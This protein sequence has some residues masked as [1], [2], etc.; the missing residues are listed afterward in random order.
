[1]M[2]LLS[3]AASVIG[4]AWLSLMI[5]APAFFVCYAAWTRWSQYRA[6]KRAMR[7]V[8]EHRRP[9]PGG[10]GT[11]KWTTGGPGRADYFAIDLPYGITETPTVYLTESEAEFGRPMSCHGPGYWQAWKASQDAKAPPGRSRYSTID[12]LIRESGA[13]PP[14]ELT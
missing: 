13:A 10:A 2:A 1:M 8:R 9:E 11:A 12:D 3:R 14:Q 4:W 6:T 5:A 7:W